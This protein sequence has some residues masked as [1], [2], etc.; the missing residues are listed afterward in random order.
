[1]ERKFVEVTLAKQI[2]IAQQIQRIQNYEYILFDKNFIK[3][4]T[5]MV[6][7]FRVDVDIRGARAILSEGAQQCFTTSQYYSYVK[8]FNRI[9]ILGDRVVLLKNQS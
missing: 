1:M 5:E 8:H 9:A 2:N 4:K 3:S 6:G 7:H